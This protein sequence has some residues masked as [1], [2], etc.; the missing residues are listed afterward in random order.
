MPAL[1]I[2]EARNRAVELDVTVRH[3]PG[4][5]PPGPIILSETTRTIE[6]G[7][8][9]QIILVP[10]TLGTEEQSDGASFA[11]GQ[12]SDLVLKL[13]GSLDEAPSGFDPLPAEAAPANP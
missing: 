10:G 13:Q 12:T 3:V 9:L 2:A 8:V 11:D 7:E 5:S 1:Q 4:D 6:V